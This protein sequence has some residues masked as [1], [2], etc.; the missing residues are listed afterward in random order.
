MTAPQTPGHKEM[1]Q[2]VYQ[3][4]IEGMTCASCVSRVERALNRVPGVSHA[5]VNLAM[6]QAQVIGERGKVGLAELVL[7]VGKAGYAAAPVPK[8]GSV[9]KPE[10][11]FW[12]VVGLSALLT[13]PLVLPMVLAPF[14]WHVM[15]PPL[16][17]LLLASPVQFIFGW[18]FYVAGFK[19]L[20]DFSGNMDLLVA[21][22]TT[23]AFSLSV[24]QMIQGHED[25]YFESSAVIITLV[26]LGK[27]LEQRAKR[28]TTAAIRALSDLRPTTAVVLRDGLEVVIGLSDVCVG[29]LVVVKPGERVAADGQIHTGES[30]IDESLITGESLPVFKSPGDRVT[31]GSVNIDG[32]VVV[33][34]TAVGA[35]TMLARIIRLVEDAQAVKAPIQRRVDQISAVFVPSV[36][37][38]AI[39]TFGAWFLWTGS[40][41]IA[42]M[43]AVAVL[44]IACPCALGLATPT[45]IMVG[46]GVA[47]RHG[48][49]IKDAE[50]LESAH[51]VSIVVFDKTGTL[52]EGKPELWG[53][54][55][56]SG[57]EQT[58]LGLAASV[59]AG[60]EHPLAGAV[61]KEAAHRG[62]SYAVAQNVRA[63]PGRGV[64]GMVRGRTILIGNRKMFPVPGVL[65]EAILSKAAQGEA[66][67]KTSAFIAE[68]NSDGMMVLG[69]LFFQD[70]IRP[71]SKAAITAL[72]RL[73]IKTV[74]LT[75]DH[76]ESAM[77]VASEIGIDDV[78]ADVLPEDKGRMIAALKKEGDSPKGEIVAMI[79]DGINDAPAL[80]MADLGIAMG[81][82]SD[83]AMQS[84]QITLM[85]SDPLMVPAAIDISHRTYRNIEQNLFWAM[86]YNIVGIPLA[87]IGVMSPVIAGAA[88]AMS[89][90]SVVSNALRLRRWYPP[91]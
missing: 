61:I 37:L 50:A 90:V 45:A 38:I 82:G 73:G 56:V 47:A 63:V 12:A 33:K 40:L 66:K 18:R 19:A 3:L 11:G 21:L 13:L 85:R 78:K 23:A 86:I 53:I 49:L 36:L 77:I 75:G 25:L 7:A 72:H 83:V 4:K 76:R 8:Q 26:R 62:I 81:S 48:I 14:G 32:R 64:R 34:V 15:L 54:E 70:A 65:P 71:S 2:E 79:G 51:R 35:E 57:D 6:E 89:S 31:G 22:G 69:I 5:S 41:P 20:R 52:T 27:W 17:Q 39:V 87:A 60:S 84:A 1:S 67:G 59:Q 24:A 44:V 30:S 46:T 16:V 74:L 91:G 42:V 80:A 9:A 28:E 55:S 68:E 10:S 58:L 29:D 43:H 88:M